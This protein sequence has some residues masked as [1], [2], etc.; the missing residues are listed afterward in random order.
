MLYNT[1]ANAVPVRYG[2]C[3]SVSDLWHVARSERCHDRNV[4]A[5]SLIS[6]IGIGTIIPD[7]YCANANELEKTTKRV[8]T[9]HQTAV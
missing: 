9:I 6:P 3:F 1:E 4:Q 7:I 2:I 5:P 8:W